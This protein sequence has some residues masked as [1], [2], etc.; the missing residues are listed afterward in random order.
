M[1]FHYN[2]GFFW[3]YCNS[4]QG[5]QGVHLLDVAMWGIAGM[6]GL[7]N[8]LPTKV[9]GQA[10]IYWLHDIKEV[11]DTQVTCYDYGDFMLVWEL[12]SFQDHHPLEGNEGG[13]A[14]YGSEATLVVDGDGWKVFAKDGKPGPSEKA[15]GGSHIQTF[16]DCMKSRQ[17]PLADVEAGRL[18]TTIC[19]LG[20][21]NYH[22]QRDL[23]FDPKTETFGDDTEANRY[24]KKSYREPYVLP[25]V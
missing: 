4:E 10:G 21:I 3:D 11:P 7:D 14:F 5:N 20:N 8:A 17:R 23:V 22:L 2:W 25:K 19:H 9:S 6:R 24:L 18:S 15:S 16:V 13:T 12:R 1:G